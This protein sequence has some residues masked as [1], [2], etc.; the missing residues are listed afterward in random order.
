M[1]K[2]EGK[3]LGRGSFHETGRETNRVGEENQGKGRGQVED[4]LQS[5]IDKIV[6]LWIQEY[7]TMDTTILYN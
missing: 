4:I 1:W 5:K 3:K 6:F 2:L 7:G